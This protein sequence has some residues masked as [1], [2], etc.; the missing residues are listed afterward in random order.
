MSLSLRMLHPHLHPT[1]VAAVWRALEHSAQPLYFLTWGW[2]VTWLACLPRVDVP[3]LAVVF[4]NGEPIAA[5]FLGQ[6]RL[7]RHHILP[8]RARYLNATGVVHHDELCAEHNAVLCA[9]GRRLRAAELVGLVPDD[10][11]ELFL[12]AAARSAFPDLAGEGSVVAGCRV[13]I[14]REVASPFIDLAQ[15]RGSPGGYLG[16][17]GSNTRA[18]IRRARRA[19]GPLELEAARDPREARAMFDE[20]ITLHTRTWN[21]RGEGGAFADPWFR[22]FHEQLIDTRF[23]HGEIE[24]LRLR[25]GATT[26]G[27]LYNLVAN[28]RVLFYQSGLATFDDKHVKPGYLCHAAAIERAAAAGHAIYDLL[29]GDARYKRCLATGEDQLA[30]FRLQRP[31]TRFLIEDWVRTQKRAMTRDAELVAVS[32]D[33]PAMAAESRDARRPLR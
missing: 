33:A 5:G 26:V 22:R 21:A 24:L 12:P 11:D 9:P 28:G 13:R 16:L 25:S 4:D 7:R 10:W 18:Q 29:G 19:I 31:R 14:D 8:S 23:A 15:V 6:R 3:E 2:I 27:C 30:W 32:D 17:L 1:Q 20:L